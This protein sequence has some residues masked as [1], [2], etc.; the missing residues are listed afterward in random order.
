MP[1][2]GQIRL[3]VA[4]CRVALVS[5]KHWSRCPTVARCR[6]TLVGIIGVG[7][8]AVVG[9][10][11][12][13]PAEDWRGA[14]RICDA[15]PWY[16]RDQAER[17]ACVVVDV[18]DPDLSLIAAPTIVC[19]MVGES[20]RA[21]VLCLR[22]DGWTYDDNPARLQPSWEAHWGWGMVVKSNDV[23][24]SIEATWLRIGGFVWDGRCG[25]HNN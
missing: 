1:H 3:E 9:S 21:L 15:T 4:L 7:A 5:H 19:R 12:V 18:H 24:C 22:A 25:V 8:T 16:A 17:R 20:H 10:A 23:E 14:R 2:L 6:S 13:G 11:W